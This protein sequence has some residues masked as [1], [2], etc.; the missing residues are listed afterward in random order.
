MQTAGNYVDMMRQEQYAKR[1]RCKK[2]LAKVQYERNLMQ[3]QRKMIEKRKLDQ[4]VTARCR[5][6]VDEQIRKY[7]CNAELNR[8]MQRAD[9][10]RKHH[11]N[12]NRKRIVENNERHQMTHALIAEEIKEIDR[13]NLR[14]LKDKIAD[15]D[16]KSNT[17]RMSKMQ[18]IEESRDRAQITA[19]LR[20]IVRKS[21]TP[22]NF[23][24][25]V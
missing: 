22:D 7:E 9:F 20:D 3:Y 16:R 11:L 4:I 8:R 21:A 12:I 10:I 14:Y 25:S 5:L 18:W 17:I 24:Y 19:T 1:L 15:C 6:K 2:R 13:L 23:L